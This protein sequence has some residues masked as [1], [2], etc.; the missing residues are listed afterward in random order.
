MKRIFTFMLLLVVW[1]V[2]AAMGPEQLIKQTSDK[3]L[4]EIK[5]NADVYQS[6]PERIY[7]LVDDVVLPHFDFSAMTDLALGKYKDKVNGE[8]RPTIVNEFRS[9]LVRTYSSALLEY[10]DQEL[11]YLPMEGVESDGI[12]TVRTEI[13]QAGGFPIP[14]NYTLRL[15][16]EG[17]KVFDISVDDVSLVTNYRSSFARAIKKDGVDGLI[18]T[19]QDRNQEQ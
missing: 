14:I 12:V 4:A 18:K 2:F 6:D 5:A 10:T 19:L 1:P 15:G 11:I 16:D 13:E 3:V 17:W 9:L 8:Q 7:Q